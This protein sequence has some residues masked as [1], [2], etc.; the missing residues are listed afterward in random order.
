M[1]VLGHVYQLQSGENGKSHTSSGKAG[2][3]HQRKHYQY[4]RMLQMVWCHRLLLSLSPARTKRKACLAC[5]L[6]SVLP[7][8]ISKLMQHKAQACI[9]PTSHLA[10]GELHL[11]NFYTRKQ[12][13]PLARLTRWEMS[14]RK[15]AEAVS[16]LLQVNQ[17]GKIKRP[18]LLTPGMPVVTDNSIA[19]RLQ[20]MGVRWGD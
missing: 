4:V 11:F 19:V 6:V 17:G 15:K 20:G 3:P 10:N 8:S 2:V 16:L 5:F 13:S 9:L 18:H 7:N 14:S 12:C 1:L